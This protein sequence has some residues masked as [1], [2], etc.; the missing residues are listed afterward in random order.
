MVFVASGLARHHVV[1]FFDAGS[2][3]S[4]GEPAS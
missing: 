4:L 2:I 3:H 1:G